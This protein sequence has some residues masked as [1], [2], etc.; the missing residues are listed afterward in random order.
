MARFLIN[1]DTDTPQPQDMRHPPRPEVGTTLAGRPVKQ[2]YAG[3]DIVYSI[4][5]YAKMKKLMS[6]YDPA[7]PSVTI[8][9][10]DPITGSSVTRNA[11]MHEPE[12]GR[13]MTLYFA[14]VV[15][16]FTRVTT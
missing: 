1:G 6:L 7:D 5:N 16:R 9:Y 14:D 11:M 12:I 13:R 15:V 4:L 2:G 10:D 3:V 8:T